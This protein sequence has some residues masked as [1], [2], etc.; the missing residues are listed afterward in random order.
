MIIFF[1]RASP[2]TSIQKDITLKWIAECEYGFLI[3]LR[4]RER[5]EALRPVN[6]AVPTW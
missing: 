2:P 4:N 6:A 5:N 3:T 1:M